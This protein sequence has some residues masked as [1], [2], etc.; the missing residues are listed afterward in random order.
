[1]KREIV[2][3]PVMQL[4]CP[5]RDSKKKTERERE[6]GQ[7]EWSNGAGRKKERK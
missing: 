4:T 7:R 5:D 1:M 3:L 2:T 6:G